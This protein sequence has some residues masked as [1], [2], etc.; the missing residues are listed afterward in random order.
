MVASATTAAPARTFEEF[1]QRADYSLL[2]ALRP[3]PEAGSRAT[4]TGPARCSPGT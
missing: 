4:T 2:D 1:A 3:D